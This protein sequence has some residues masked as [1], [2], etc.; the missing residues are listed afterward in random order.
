MVQSEPFEE[1]TKSI[2]KEMER[3]RAALAEGN[4]GKARVCARRAAGAAIAL[5]A[6]FG[7]AMPASTSAMR[8]L[9]TIANHP[10]VPIEV[11]EA[12]RRLGAKLD[13]D[14]RR[15]ITQNPIADATL[16]ISYARTSWTLPES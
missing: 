5:M 7:E 3:A 15:H 4:E 16:V 11:Q 1:A 2:H 13:G 8:R 12:A 9:E 14:G 10:T 6:D